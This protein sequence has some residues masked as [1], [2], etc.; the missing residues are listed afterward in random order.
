MAEALLISSVMPAVSNLSWL[1]NRQQPSTPWMR[2]RSAQ[3]VNEKPIVIWEHG[4]RQ[5]KDSRGGDRRDSSLTVW[6][7]SAGGSWISV[8]VCLGCYNK[9]PWTRWLKMLKQAFICHSSGGREVQDLGVGRFSSRWESSSWLVDGHLLTVSSH[10]VG[11]EAEG[12]GLREKERERER[13][14]ER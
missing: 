14:R 6:C 5:F 13:E 9:V 10:G 7:C 1:E 12:E 2:Q 11:G 4:N 3:P 8:L